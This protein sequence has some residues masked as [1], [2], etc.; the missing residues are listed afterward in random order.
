MDSN[1]FEDTHQALAKQTSQFLY[2]FLFGISSDNEKGQPALKVFFE[3]I[4]KD[5]FLKKTSFI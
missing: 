4:M 2:K 5:F 1:Q 3:E